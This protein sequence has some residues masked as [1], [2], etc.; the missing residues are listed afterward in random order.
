MV[1][2]NPYYSLEDASNRVINFQDLLRKHGITISP[3]S[4]LD[5]ISYIVLEQYE[6]HKHPELRNSM[7]D[8]RPEIREALGL[9]DFIIKII[10]VSGHPDFDKL[11]PHLRLLNSSSIPQTTRSSVSDQGS[12]KLFELYLATLSLRCFEKVDIDSPE[13]SLGDNPDIM[14]DF[15]KKRWS[16]ACK[17]MHTDNI[18]TLLDNVEKGVDQIERSRADTGIVVISLKNILEY[19]KLWPILNEENFRKGAEPLFGAFRDISIPRDI[20]ASYGPTIRNKIFDSVGFAQFEK[21]FETK[22]TV[23]GFM[24]S[25]HTA[26]SVVKDKKP[27]IAILRM[28]NI[29]QREEDFN[30]EEFSLLSCLNDAM[31]ANS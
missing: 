31:Q 5:R 24:I 2:H 10:A 19:D 14:F 30:E 23:R 7:V 8:I 12:N 29:I 13:R 15:N 4:E 26:T 6:K 1:G 11:V 18:K 22:K 25:C 3:N 9:N 21:I 16:F 27:Q 17:V 20:L 28:F